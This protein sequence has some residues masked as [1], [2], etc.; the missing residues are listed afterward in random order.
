MR[1]DTK[2]IEKKWHPNPIVGGFELCHQHKGN[3]IIFSVWNGDVS[4]ND[5]FL[6][7]TRQ[8]VA[9]HDMPSKED[10]DWLVE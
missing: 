8:E 2:I 4:A 9:Y 1:N 10:I 3:N 7:Y 6:T 5:K